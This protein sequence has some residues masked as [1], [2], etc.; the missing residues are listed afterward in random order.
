MLFEKRDLFITDVAIIIGDKVL[1]KLFYNE[2]SNFNICE[3]EYNR[4]IDLTK[5]TKIDDILKLIKK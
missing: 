3:L 4:L 5:N 1:Q 2:T